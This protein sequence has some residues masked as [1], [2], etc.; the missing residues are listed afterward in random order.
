M[1]TPAGSARRGG[2]ESAA[3]PGPGAGSSRRENGAPAA[4]GNAVLPSGRA[5]SPLKK[6]GKRYLEVSESD[7]DPDT[8]MR[9]ATSRPA[10]TSRPLR[11]LPSPPRSSQSSIAAKKGSRV[12]AAE[13]LSRLRLEKAR[14]AREQREGREAGVGGGGGGGGGSGWNSDTNT[15]HE[16]KLHVRHKSIIYAKKVAPSS[17]EHAKPGAGSS[18]R[19]R[20][21]LEHTTPTPTGRKAHQDSASIRNSSVSDDGNDS[22]GSNP[23]RPRD[24]AA[25]QTAAGALRGPVVSSSKHVG[26]TEQLA[27]LRGELKA[28]LAEQGL[29]QWERIFLEYSNAEEED[30]TLSL[31]QL[32]QA[33]A[34][35]EELSSAQVPHTLIQR[36]FAALVA[37]QSEDAHPNPTDTSG[38]LAVDTLQDWWGHRQLV[39]FKAATRPAV[40]TP[41][42]STPHGLQLV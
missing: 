33:F 36:I 32:Q 40:V 18:R 31:A 8:D 26:L 37:L 39:A 9:P 11:P 13:A 12:A 34:R 22:E 28:L 42:R 3:P 19:A 27:K 30:G 15:F 21:P 1:Q 7:P 5:L 6:V 24:P 16:Q 29:V 20:P 2:S 41:R 23:N 38:R 4:G 35:D 10:S 25:F 14:L 17:D